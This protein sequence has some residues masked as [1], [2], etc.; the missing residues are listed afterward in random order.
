[1][2]TPTEWPPPHLV[3][4]RCDRRLFSESVSVRPWLLW[5]YHWRLLRLSGV[6]CPEGTPYGYGSCLGT[7][8]PS[9]VCVLTFEASGV[10]P[11]NMPPADILLLATDYHEVFLD[12]WSTRVTQT[13]CGIRALRRAPCKDRV[14]TAATVTQSSRVKYVAWNCPQLPSG[15][16][17]QREGGGDL[18]SKELIFRSQS[19]PTPWP[20]PQK[21][22]GWPSFL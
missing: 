13:F 6:S 16:M 11:E 10:P 1:M 22:C 15:S 18:C 8:S 21:A 2:A 14:F 4:K 20:L 3:R 5:S 7:G 12:E 9:H 19:P 17:R